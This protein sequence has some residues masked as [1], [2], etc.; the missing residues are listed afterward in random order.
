MNTMIENRITHFFFTLFLII[1]VSTV[2]SA[3]IHVKGYYR[4]DR[5]YVRPHVR[6]NPDGNPY[7]NWSYPGNVNPYTSKVATGNPETYLRNYRKSGGR[8]YNTAV[9]QSLVS[10]VQVRVSANMLNVRQFPSVKSTIMGNLHCSDIIKVQKIQGGWDLIKYH[11]VDSCYQ[12]KI[13]KGYVATRY[14]IRK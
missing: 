3:Q 5:T 10:N 6:S 12:M 2:C 9:S 4:K 1:V 8:K 14:L 11:F 7:N 13:L